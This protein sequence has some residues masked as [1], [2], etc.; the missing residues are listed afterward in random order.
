MQAC[1]LL[2]FLLSLDEHD[3]SAR[4]R[5]IHCAQLFFEW[6]S[7][8]AGLPAALTADGLASTRAVMA[9][10]IIVNLKIV[11]LPLHNRLGPRWR[12]TSIRPC[13]GPLPAVQQ[14]AAALRGARTTTSAPA[15]QRAL[16][17]AEA[18]CCG[19]RHDSP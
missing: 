6:S 17:E 7:A 9:R 12:R 18:R 19:R 4:V 13:S 5:A 14:Y 10:L 8:A 15:V 16:P 1:H 11:Q 3:T 2:L